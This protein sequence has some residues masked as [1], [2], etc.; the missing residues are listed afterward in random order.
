[1]GVEPT[2]LG[3]ADRCFT[4]QHP[5][6][7][8]RLAA[9]DS[10]TL[11]RGRWLTRPPLIALQRYSGASARHWS[12]RSAS[13]RRHAIYRT[14]ALP[15]ELLRL[16]LVDPARIELAASRLQSGRSPV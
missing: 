10:K 3:F 6:F 7:K 12:R 9:T 5:T 11:A 14:A 16:N 4:V 2:S 13:N 8:I 15:S 1:M